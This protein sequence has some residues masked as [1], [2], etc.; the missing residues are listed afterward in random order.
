MCIGVVYSVAVRHILA[1]NKNVIAVR[2]DLVLHTIFWPGASKMSKNEK[3]YSFFQFFFVLKV[4]RT[5]RNWSDL[6]KESEF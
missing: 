5:G 6:A 1:Y 4:V 2:R 3:N